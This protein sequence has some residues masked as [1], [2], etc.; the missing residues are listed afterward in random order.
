MRLSWKFGSKRSDFET[1]YKLFMTED[2]LNKEP[3]K[4]RESINNKCKKFPIFF[5]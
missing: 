4:Q 5:R 3:E 2:E 1:K